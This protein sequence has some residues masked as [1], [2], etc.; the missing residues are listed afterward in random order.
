MSVAFGKQS[1]LAREADRQ[2]EFCGSFVRRKR[3]QQHM[4]ALWPG[5]L[6]RLGN[7]GS[8]PTNVNSDPSWKNRFS[9]SQGFFSAQFVPSLCSIYSIPVRPNT[10]IKA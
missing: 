4:R 6:H 9:K 5:G 3:K 7:V 1:L 2:E 10:E 8:N